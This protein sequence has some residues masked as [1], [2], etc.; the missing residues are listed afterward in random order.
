M[1][2]SLMPIGVGE[3]LGSLAWQNIFIPVVAFIIA[4]L[5]YFP[6]FKA[7]EKKLVAQEAEAEKAEALEAQAAQPKEVK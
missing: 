6:F 7:Y 1:I 2:G 3:F 5:C 4:G